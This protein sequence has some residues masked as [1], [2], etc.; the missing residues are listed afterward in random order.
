MGL[1]ERVDT[2]FE[3]PVYLH[4][5]EPEYLF[6]MGGRSRGLW[7]IGPEV[8]TFSGGLANRADRVTY[9]IFCKSKCEH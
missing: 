9:I 3:R 6:Y 8:G 2:F 5:D 7:M 1:Y 4:Q